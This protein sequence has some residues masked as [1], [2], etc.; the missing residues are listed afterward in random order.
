MPTPWAPSQ[1]EGMTCA[2]PHWDRYECARSRAEGWGGLDHQPGDDWDEEP[3][4]CRCHD[5]D[6]DFE[7]F[8]PDDEFDPEDD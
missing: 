1:H 2:C 8:D 4:D 7:P 6:E 5:L 3:C